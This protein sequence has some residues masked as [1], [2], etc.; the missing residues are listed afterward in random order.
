MAR[1][2]SYLQAGNG[3]KISNLLFAFLMKMIKKSTSGFSYKN[4]ARIEY[5]DEFYLNSP[6]Q[7]PKKHLC[8]PKTIPA[9]PFVFEAGYFG[10]LF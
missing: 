2:C 4:I 8:S 9:A 1:L 10:G 3:R 6:L 5:Y 7:I